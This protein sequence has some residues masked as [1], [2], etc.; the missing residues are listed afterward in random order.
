[1]AT[2]KP[3]QDAA[4]RVKLKINGKSVELNSFVQNF[5]AE[6]LLGMVKPLRGVGSVRTLT[7]NISKPRKS[8]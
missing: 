2:C 4:S 3:R 7:L 8:K 5:L 6:T 1:L